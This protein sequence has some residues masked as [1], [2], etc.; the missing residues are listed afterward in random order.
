M[1]RRTSLSSSTPHGVATVVSDP[2][3][4]LDFCAEATPERLAPIWDTLG[5][6]YEGSKN[7]VM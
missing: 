5:E 1:P 4:H 2:R 3:F 7:V 6:K